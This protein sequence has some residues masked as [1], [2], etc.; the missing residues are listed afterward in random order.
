MWTLHRWDFQRRGA[1]RRLFIADGKIEAI[2]DDLAVPR[3]TPLL[4]LAGFTVLPGLIDMH[5]HLTDRPG[6]TSDLSVYFR[7]TVE[8][9]LEEGR[10]NATRTLLARFTSVRDLGTYIGWTDKLLRDEIDSGLVVGPR[11]QVAGFY[12]TVPGGGGDLL[13][14]GVE[15]KDIPQQVRLG[16]ARGPD[17]FREKALAAVEGGADVLKVI[18]SGAV[19]A[20]GGIPG[21]PEM[22]PE[23]LRAVAEVAHAAGRKLAAH[24]HGAR[25]I[26]EAIL[27]GADTIEHASLIDAEAIALARENQV[28]LSMDVYNGDYIATEGK[29]QGWPEE[30]LRKNDETTEA[31]REGFAKANAAGVPFVYGTD[32]AV[33]PHGDNAKQFR[34]M[35]ERGM[36]PLDAI[37]A[38]TSIASRYMGWE[39]RVGALL[40]GRFGD[41]VAVAG[42]PLTDV[43]LLEDVAVVVKGGL[44][45]RAP[46]GLLSE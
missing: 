12:L 5:T 29:Q 45:F 42:D 19:L 40:P 6:S 24:A 11:M 22:T 44:V 16:V 14:P 38:A 31:Q 4:D 32:S 39:D 35:V 46:L 36:K 2:G 3:G 9:Q 28:A 27:A 41:L 26:K 7:M 43:T 1:G 15:E 10:V 30:F 17:R 37:R 34:I 8:E 18:A 20:F 13:L 23:E 21:E 33:Y 25:S